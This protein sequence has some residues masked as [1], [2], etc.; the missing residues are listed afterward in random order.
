MIKDYNTT[1]KVSLLLLIIN[2]IIVPLWLLTNLNGP[3]EYA[4]CEIKYIIN[5]DYDG[6]FRD[7]YCRGITLAELIFW[8][9]FNLILSFSIYLF[10][11]SKK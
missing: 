7:G 9:S 6:Y 3:I 5:V 11:T 8:I 2:L 10:K 1:Q 4:G